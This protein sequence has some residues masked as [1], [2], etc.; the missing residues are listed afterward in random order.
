MILKESGNDVR[1]IDECNVLWQL[2]LSVEDDDL[3][4]VSHLAR[5]TSVSCPEVK[6]NRWSE[7]STVSHVESS[8]FSNKEGETRWTKS[9]KVIVKSP[10]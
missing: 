9:Q 1:E 6:R 5:E 2:Y 3:Q 10:L 8:V 4:I 7:H